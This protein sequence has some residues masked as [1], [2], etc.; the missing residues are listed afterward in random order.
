MTFFGKTMLVMLVVAMAA[1]G[2][3]MA[4]VY[5]V[6]DSAGWTFNYN[7]NEW[8]FFKQF[9]VGDTLVFNYD[10]QLHNVRQVDINDYNSCTEINPIASFNSGS[11]SITLDTPGVDY[12]FLC[13][14][15]GH[16][17]SGLKFHIK[18]SATP[19]SIPVTPPPPRTSTN[20]NNPYRGHFPSSTNNPTQ[21]MK[22]HSSASTAYSF[23][24]LFTLFLL[25]MV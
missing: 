6:G 17:A 22:P 10:P 7:Y 3:T 11:D 14:I 4:T 19:T 13:G 5:Q 2:S 16:C 21:T 15:P 20:T 1:W 18:I 12:F 8:A 24:M 9:Q 25:A 23:N